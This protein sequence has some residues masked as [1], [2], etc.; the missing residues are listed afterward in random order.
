MATPADWEAYKTS[1]TTQKVQHLLKLLTQQQNE[2]VQQLAIIT[3]I[4]QELAN[5]EQAPQINELVNET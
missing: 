2:P 4:R 3:K 5:G 1:T